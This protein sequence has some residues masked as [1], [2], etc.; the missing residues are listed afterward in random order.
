MATQ[1]E[2]AKHL[3][4]SE[5]AVRD[6]LKNL[7]IEA[8]KTT[9]DKA[10]VAYIRDL[11][12]KAAGRVTSEARERRDE[13]QALESEISAKL[14]Q[15]ELAR[16]DGLIVSIEGVRLAFIEWVTLAKSE[17]TGFFQTYSDTIENEHGIEID[18]EKHKHLVDDALRSIGDYRLQSEESDN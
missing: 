1:K 17:F 6:V 16:Q 2:I 14:K 13:A 7:G 12:E 15:R 18:K 4:M 11:R 5:R 10:R 8:S 9:V 3:D